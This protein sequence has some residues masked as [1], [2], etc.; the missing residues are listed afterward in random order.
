MTQQQQNQQRQQQPPRQT[1]ERRASAAPSFPGAQHDP[2][3]IPTRKV[4]LDRSF[5][6]HGKLYGPGEVDVPEVLEVS[7]PY[8]AGVAELRPADDLEIAMARAIQ[9][10]IA[11][12]RVEPPT[13]DVFDM[14]VKRG[15]HVSQVPQLD[16]RMIR[17]G[18]EAQGRPSQLTDGS[19]T[20]L[21]R[22][23]HTGQPFVHGA[24]FGRLQ[25][26]SEKQASR[27]TRDI[28][29]GREGPQGSPPPRAPGQ[30]LTIE[31]QERAN[32]QHE[33]AQQQAQQQQAQPQQNP[34][35]ASGGQNQGK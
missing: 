32:Q 20:T 21:D 23:T 26:K 30:P 12:G 4:Y 8:G 19:I 16:D 9:N 29:A 6:Y 11:A 35:G 24:T 25:H 34:G 17:A 2:N 22:T 28:L 10:D 14:D 31:E 15:P 7:N 3:R 33:E 13:D 5:T 27:G 18:R 1:G